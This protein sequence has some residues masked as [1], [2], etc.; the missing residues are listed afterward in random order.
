MS[1]PAGA[2]TVP[3]SITAFA[4]CKVSAPAPVQVSNVPGDIWILPASG[5]AEDAPPVET[6][7]SALARAFASVAALIFDTPVGAAP[8]A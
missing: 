5:P 1:V 4:A 3:S 7:T 2:E 6:V 8:K